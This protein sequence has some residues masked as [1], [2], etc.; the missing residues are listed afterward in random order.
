MAGVQ[1][2][3]SKKLKHRTK[4]TDLYCKSCLE[5]TLSL[6]DSDCP[7][8]LYFCEHCRR[9]YTR[10]QVLTFDEMINAKFERVKHRN[11]RQLKRDMRP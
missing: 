2:M 6:K 1:G 8:R 7:N 10:T 3:S 5:E 4:P 9:K 11:L